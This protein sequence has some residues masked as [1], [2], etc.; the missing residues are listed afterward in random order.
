MPSPLYNNATL[1]EAEK[2]R[3]FTTTVL[4]S[5]ENATPFDDELP[6]TLAPVQQDPLEAA[7]RYL[8]RAPDLSGVASL[9]D[10]LA[11]LSRP[12]H[13]VARQLT[14]ALTQ[15][16]QP[17]MLASLV[18]SPIQPVAAGITAGT[19]GLSGLRKLLMPEEDESRVGGAIE[20]GLGL[21]PGLG[22]LRK[23]HKARLASRQVDPEAAVVRETV[24]SA[25]AFQQGGAS[26][27]QAAQRAGWPLGKS[28]SAPSMPASVPTARHSAASMQGLERAAASRPAPETADALAARI[29][30][31][32]VRDRPRPGMP[33]DVPD[34]PRARALEEARQAAQTRPA[35][36]DDPFGASTTLRGGRESRANLIHDP[37][38]TTRDLQAQ[39]QAATTPEERAYLQRVLTQRQ[40]VRRKLRE[41]ARREE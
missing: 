8:A 6:L 25:R 15:I 31:Q 2:R 36:N 30:R 26:R 10:Q 40:V 27:A 17:A 21:L 7:Q 22:T 16:S 33:G 4:P 14:D 38:Y 37:A 23:L 24:K 3:R 12:S 20:A 28:R 5:R 19:L 9:P 29:D 32:L 34:N 39:L 18:P 1:A 13:G 35:S 11:A 41:K